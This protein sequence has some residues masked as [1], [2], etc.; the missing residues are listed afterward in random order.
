MFHGF[1]PRFRP[2]GKQLLDQGV[3]DLQKM[4]EDNRQALLAEWKKDVR[5]ER[6]GEGQDAQNLIGS[7]NRRRSKKTLHKFDGLT[8]AQRASCVRSFEKFSH[9]S[10]E[11][12]QQFLKKRSQVE[13]N[14]RRRT[15]AMAR[16]RREGTAAA[17]DLSYCAKTHPRCPEFGRRQNRRSPQQTVNKNE[18]GLLRFES[19]N[20]QPDRFEIGGFLARDRKIRRLGD[21]SDAEET[22]RFP[23]L[24]ALSMASRNF[25]GAQSDAFR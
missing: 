13:P 7:R 2:I 16:P 6:G 9:L 15:Q 18:S 20:P 24:I 5:L 17:A 10:L 1:L 22:L 12:R 23:F 19:L 11:E 4:S 8:L 25:S 21:R 3:N 14:E